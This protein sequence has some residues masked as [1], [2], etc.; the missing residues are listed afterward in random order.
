MKIAVKDISTEVHYKYDYCD[1]RLYCEHWNAEV[2]PACCNGNNCGCTGLDSVYCSDC[3]NEDLTEEQAYELTINE[4]I[5]HYE[6]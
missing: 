5:S 1:D 4:R 2:E 6:D 3:D